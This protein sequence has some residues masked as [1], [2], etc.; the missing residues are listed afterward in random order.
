MACTQICYL[1][2]TSRLWSYIFSELEFWYCNA[3]FRPAF[4]KIAKNGS[5]TL[6]EWHRIDKNEIAKVEC[7]RCIRARADPADVFFWG[8]GGILKRCGQRTT[9]AYLENRQEGDNPKR[10]HIVT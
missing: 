9:V 4:V 2:E 7:I 8:G 6:F 1:L 5:R 3:S 10:A